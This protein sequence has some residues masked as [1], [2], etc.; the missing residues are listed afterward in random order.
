[1]DVG[2]HAGQFTKLFSGMVPAGHVYAFEPGEYAL[3]IL[4]KVQ[5]LRS[6][7]NVTIVPLGLGDQ[8]TEAVLSIPIKKSGSLG[9]GLSSLGSVN[10]VRNVQKDTVFLT[11]LDLFCAQENPE[12]VD[13]IKADIEGWELNM[14]K[15]ARETLAKYR[16][17]IMLEI[18]E[19]ALQGANA[20]S[21]DLKEFLKNQGYVIS[22]VL[23]EC[24]F[25]PKERVAEIA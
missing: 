6:L 19:A 24:V 8:P 7:K 23:N 10:D 25:V 9:F 4:R 22:E 2:A 13:F 3:S 18:N 14:L 5:T 16:P 11:T 20:S 1:M 15:G 21:D 12:R 17:V